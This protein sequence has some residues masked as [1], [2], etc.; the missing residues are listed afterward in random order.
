MNNTILLS[1][2]LLLSFSGFGQ[3]SDDSSNHNFSGMA[4]SV[5]NTLKPGVV[6]SI[7]DDFKSYRESNSGVIDRQAL[8]EII[9]K[10]AESRKQIA[11]KSGDH[12]YIEFSTFRIKSDSEFAVTNLLNKTYIQMSSCVQD[13]IRALIKSKK[14]NNWIVDGDTRYRLRVQSMSQFP[15]TVKASA[16]KS[17]IAMNENNKFALAERGVIDQCLEFNYAQE[18]A[19]G[20][21]CAYYENGV[22]TYSDKVLSVLQKSADMEVSQ[23]TK[24]N[25]CSVATYMQPQLLTQACF[26]MPDGLSKKVAPEYKVDDARFVWLDIEHNLDGKNFVPGYSFV[27]FMPGKLCDET[28]DFPLNINHP[29]KLYLSELTE[30][31]ENLLHHVLVSKETDRDQIIKMIGSFQYAWSVTMPLMRG[32]AAVSEFMTEALYQVFGYKFLDFQSEL[33]KTADLA[34]FMCW[35]ETKFIKLYSQAIRLEKLSKK[36]KSKK[37]RSNKLDK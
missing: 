37:K 5:F 16:L 25:K 19:L 12:E 10:A 20:G 9:T 2:V 14:A 7:C 3:A 24:K 23:A 36:K 6:S 13:Q 32:S 17:F 22:V 31:Y 1:T 35:T 18:L 29:G 28:G 21:C 30:K 26:V 4:N 8:N 33:V 15:V 34:S 27:G 11:Y